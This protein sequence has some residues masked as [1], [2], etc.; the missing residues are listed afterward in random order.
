MSPRYNFHPFLAGKGAGGC[1]KRG[2]SA[3][4]WWRDLA[5]E[6]QRP[7]EFPAGCGKRGV[8][9]GGA[10][11]AGVWGCP[12]GTVSTP[13][14]LGRGQG[15]ARKGVFQQPAGGEISHGDAEARRVF[16]R[17]QKEGSPE[18]R[19]PIGGGLGVSPRYNFHP[20]LAGKGAGGCSKGFFSNLVVARFS[21]RDAEARRVSVLSECL[22]GLGAR[23]LRMESCGA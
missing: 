13:S 11:L 17:L 22:R 15:D 19:S 12:P 8:Q 20:F 2:F 10:P 1:S 14:W 6:T 23:I 4:C 5:T 9:R 7:G 16:G 18:G 3:T 21:H